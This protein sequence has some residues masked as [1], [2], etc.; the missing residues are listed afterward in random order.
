MLGFMRNRKQ[1]VTG[2]GVAQHKPRTV[3]EHIYMWGASFW[4]PW[5][6]VA[7]PLAQQH[8]DH[9]VSQFKRSTRMTELR[10]YRHGP[11]LTIDAGE[12]CLHVD[13]ILDGL[14]VIDVVHED[15]RNSGDVDRLR[16]QTSI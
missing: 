1:R 14:A 13:L 12:R 2:G 9:L 15:R 5:R 7:S 8:L 10:F 16:T 11:K 3:P 6:E 4:D